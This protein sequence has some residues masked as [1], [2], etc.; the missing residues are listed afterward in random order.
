MKSKVQPSVLLS[1]TLNALLEGEKTTDS[2]LND[3]MRTS[4]ARVVQTALESEVSEFL[5]REPY[6]RERSFKGAAGLRNGY[7]P[8]TLKTRLD[9]IPFK[10]PLVYGTP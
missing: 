3:L 7:T 4:F 9:R 10:R 8:I 2:L 5:G 6:Q 1:Q